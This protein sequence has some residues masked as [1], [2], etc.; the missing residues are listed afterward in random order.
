[1]KSLGGGWMTCTAA[2]TANAPAKTPV[3][4]TSSDF[5]TFLDVFIL[6]PPFWGPFT[7][8]STL[9]PICCKKTFATF[10]AEGGIKG[11]QCNEALLEKEKQQMTPAQVLLTAAIAVAVGFWVGFDLGYTLGHDAGMRGAK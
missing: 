9:K 1:M 3:E 4:A 7:I 5:L 10:A 6:P 2:E 11:E 8:D